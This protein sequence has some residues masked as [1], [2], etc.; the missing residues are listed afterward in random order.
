M[1][2]SMEHEY[3]KDILSVYYDQ[4]L[5]PEQTALVAE[6]LETCSECQAEMEKLDKLQQLVQE[7]SQLS[8][9]DYWEK[10]AQKIEARL[11][12]ETV[13]T[14]LAPE[15][16]KSS[17]LGW[18]LLGVAASVAFLTW[19]GVNRDMLLPGDSERQP[20]STPS[21]SVLEAEPPSES[22]TLHAPTP[23]DVQ[24]S[25]TD[26]VTG[27][28]QTEAQKRTPQAKPDRSVEETRQEQSQDALVGEEG[29]YSAPAESPVLDERESAKG[30]TATN[31]AA[32][33]T[34]QADK[35]KESGI[36]EFLGESLTDENYR[37][38][39]TSSSVAAE[40]K[41]ASGSVRLQTDES[42]VYSLEATDDLVANE[43]SYWRTRIDSLGSRVDL[44]SDT[45]RLKQSSRPRAFGYSDKDRSGASSLLPKSS[46]ESA[47]VEADSVSEQ[48]E[49]GIEKELVKAWYEICRLSPDS[50]ET[51][52]GVDFLRSIAANEKSDN[53]SLA[54]DLLSK[55]GLE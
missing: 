11:G 36:D 21:E 50:T 44:S 51:K 15:K 48:E 54:K 5:T 47:Q 38:D 34:V 53:R 22:K 23:A 2:N 31:Q 40:P 24:S 25:E 6:H 30:R 43:L 55:L 9:S 49:T 4:E 7:R 39:E 26:R 41:E 18:K 16:A 13:V 20:E 46:A 19:V 28:R 52:R 37:R 12:A 29:V 27:Q 32:A 35:F 1:G 10:S 3:I 45:L 33:K 42:Q 8:D 14:D 17:G